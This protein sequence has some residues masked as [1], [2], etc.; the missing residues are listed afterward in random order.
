[1]ALTMA[2]MSS[3]A[4]YTGNMALTNDYVLYC[5]N[6]LLH[7]GDGPDHGPLNRKDGPDH[8][9]HAGGPGSP[10]GPPAG[11][12]GGHPGEAGAAHRVAG[13]RALQREESLS[14]DRFL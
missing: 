13:A 3:M 11:G 1:M 10:H 12:A 7:R 2:S 5:P 14:D 4:S 6:G 9:L 8:G